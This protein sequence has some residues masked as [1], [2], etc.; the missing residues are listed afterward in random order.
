MSSSGDEGLCPLRTFS[1]RLKGELC[2]RLSKTT[3][4]LPLLNLCLL[5]CN[6]LFIAWYYLSV[7]PFK[8]FIVW[9]FFDAC[10]WKVIYELTCIDSFFCLRPDRPDF[11]LEMSFYV[12]ME[13]MSCVFKSLFL[14][15]CLTVC[16]CPVCFVFYL[17]FSHFF[18]SLPHYLPVPQR[19]I[20]L[21]F[22]PL[23]LSYCC[24]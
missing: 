9:R 22:W 2:G 16:L 8:S 5:W 23:W 17:S 24:L 20:L 1:R 14:C 12:R 15:L 21:L 13:D 7:S 6:C 4:D 3:E 19:R 10:S 18:L 11:C